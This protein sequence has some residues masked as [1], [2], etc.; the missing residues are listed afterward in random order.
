MQTL[1]LLVSRVDPHT[2]GREGEE[3]GRDRGGGNEGGEREKGDNP[4][5][6]HLAISCLYTCHSSVWPHTALGDPTPPPA[7]TACSH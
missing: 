5:L 3:G 6:S 4:K 1:E 2:P 7:H